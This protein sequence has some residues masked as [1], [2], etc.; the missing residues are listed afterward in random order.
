MTDG[1]AHGGSFVFEVEALPSGYSDLTIYLAFDYARGRTLPERIYWRLFKLFFPE[2]IHDVLWNHALCEI[3]HLA[4]TRDP[5][6]WQ[7]QL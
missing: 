7:M 2:F 1:F 6:S 4:E 5:V 3:K